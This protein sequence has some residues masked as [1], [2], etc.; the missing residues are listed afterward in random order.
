VRRGPFK[1]C[2]GFVHHCPPVARATL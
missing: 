1:G 2:P